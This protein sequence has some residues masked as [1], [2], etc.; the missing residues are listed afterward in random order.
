MQTSLIIQDT[1]KCVISHAIIFINIVIHSIAIDVFA[2]RFKCNRHINWQ[3]VKIS[4]ISLKLHNIV[5]SLNGHMILTIKY[6]IL[7]YV[8][9]SS[10]LHAVFIS[11]AYKHNRIK[12]R[13]VFIWRQKQSFRQKRM[14]LFLLNSHFTQWSIDFKWTQVKKR[15]KT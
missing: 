3:Q 10:S 13:S 7:R 11:Y 14:L 15:I 5:C 6:M 8:S 2:K 1:A 4:L 9:I 12:W